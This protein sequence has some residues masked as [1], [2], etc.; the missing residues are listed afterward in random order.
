MTDPDPSPSTYGL[1]EA[2]AV[3]TP[4]DNRVLYRGWADSYEED[5]VEALGYIY[6]EGVARV[7]A[8]KLPPTDEP[9]L[10]VGCGTGVVG[11]A[12]AKHGYPTVDGIDISPEMLQQSASKDVYRSLVEADLT[13][14]ISLAT[15][16]YAGIV[17]I[18]HV[19]SDVFT[20]D[21]V[22]GD[23]TDAIYF[24]HVPIVCSVEGRNL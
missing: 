18:D 14:P 20:G 4:D 9:I 3:Q 17:S 1:E 19:A 23:V 8:S 2:Y 15:A 21:C 7:L 16:T 10:D 24:D 6:H 11:V 22:V 5:F 12:L 13:K